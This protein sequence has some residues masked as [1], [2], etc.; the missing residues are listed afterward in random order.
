M[1]RQLAEIDR[2]WIFL[3]MGLAV[4]IPVLFQ[5]QLQAVLPEYPGSQAQAVFEEIERLKP[6]DRVLMAWDFDPATEGE[7]S[8]MA[9]AMAYH[10]A[11]KKARLYFIT[12]LPVGPQ[13]IDKTIQS[14]IRLDFPDMVYGEDYVNLGFKSGYEG[15]IKVIVTDLR[16]LYSTDSRGTNIDLIPMCKEIENIQQMDLIV[17]V[18]GAYP[19]SKEWIQYAVTPYQSKL[20]MVAGCTGVQSPLMYPYIPNQLKGLLGAIKGA[21]EYEMLV[22]DRYMKENP[23]PKYLEGRRRMGPQLVA[24]LLM[25]LLIVVGNVIYFAQRN[26][27]SAAG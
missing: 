6:G 5:E 24:H 8:P 7:L 15:V 12:L 18:S 17:N 23:D 26:S 20:R 11:K 9:T 3:A 22:V 27:G 13:M 2:R 14:V 21:S 16:G 19:G 1:I 4:A 10:C 25:I